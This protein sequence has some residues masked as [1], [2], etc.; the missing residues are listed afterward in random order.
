MKT[1]EHLHS[2]PQ[3]DSQKQK[4]KNKAQ[5]NYIKL[6]HSWK[7]SQNNKEAKNKNKKPEKLNQQEDTSN[8]PQEGWFLWLFLH[9]LSS[10]AANHNIQT[11]IKIKS[12]RVRFLSETIM[13]DYQGATLVTW[14]HR[15]RMVNTKKN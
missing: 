14:H 15:N 11:W 2:F 1:K 8:S 12:Y 10:I 3:K 6:N 7:N 5:L 9:K 4:H 13:S